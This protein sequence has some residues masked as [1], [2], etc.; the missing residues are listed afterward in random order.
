MTRVCLIGKQ[1]VNLREELLSRDG[2]RQALSAY[3]LSEPW[4]N[5]IAVSTVSLGT[6]ISL[7]NDL[8]WYLTRFTRDAIIYDPSVSTVE[9][10]SR[11]LGEAIRDQTIRRDETGLLLKI[12]GV[13]GR[14]LVEPMYVQ[15]VDSRLPTYDLRDV[16]DTLAIQIKEEEFG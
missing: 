15:R 1:D 6:S 7:L 13:S 14:E 10:L 2:S 12:Y 3:A 9:W 11:D 16:N 8:N 4:E 5:T